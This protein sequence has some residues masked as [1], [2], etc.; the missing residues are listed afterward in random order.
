MG[1]QQNTNPGSYFSTTIAKGLNI[2]NL[3][4]ADRRQLT[5]KEVALELGIDRTSAYRYVNTLVQ[6]GYIWKDPKT[7]MLR[8]GPM[9]LTMSNTIAL[10]SD[11]LQTIKP[12]LERTLE[13][14]KG[15]IDCGFLEGDVIHRVF[16]KGHKEI[17]MRNV[18]YIE[19]ALHCSALGKVVLAH[20]PEKKM[21]SIVRG[22]D[23]T[24][25]TEHSIKD[26]NALFKD[27]EITRKRGYAI[28]NE[29][30]IIGAISIAAPFI[31]IE[32]QHAYGAVSLGFTSVAHKVSDI[33]RDYAGIAKN[34]A[35]EISKIIPIR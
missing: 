6:L 34:L 24:P 8:L 35:K 20:L 30:Y 5:L 16:Q 26:K 7:K 21:L 23:F 1:N 11:I 27:L 25:K 31:N 14:Y 4:D 13:L 29:E 32:T 15:S 22:L 17:L 9:A 2:L 12:I 19:K 10:S 3:F 18:P 33:E 28:N